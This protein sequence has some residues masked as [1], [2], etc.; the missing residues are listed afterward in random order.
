MDGTGTVDQSDAKKYN[1]QER[2][3]LHFMEH[4]NL[5][6]VAFAKQCKV[7]GSTIAKVRSG[8]P[9]R[10]SMEKR[11]VAVLEGRV[12]EG[13]EK[14]E[15]PALND[16]CQTM[17]LTILDLAEGHN[18]FD[19]LVESCLRRFQQLH[20]PRDLRPLAEQVLIT[21]VLSLPEADRVQQLF[22]LYEVVKEKKEQ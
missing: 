15:E 2:V 16:A 12:P 19:H 6:N 7:S 20:S 14:D 22:K 11:I 17:A 4:E 9:I 10:A 18:Q 1:L 8:K 21:Y 3:E 13:D 5:T